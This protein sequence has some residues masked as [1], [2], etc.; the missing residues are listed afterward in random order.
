V[1]IFAIEFFPC[2]GGMA[3]GFQMAGIEFDMAVDIDENAVVSY[4]KNLGHK[5]I[6]MDVRDLL[7]MV[8]LGWRPPR[9]D[10]LCA[11]PPC[12]PWSRAGKRLGTD[13]ERDMLKQTAELIKLLRPR[14]YLIGN[15]P[16]LQD[17]SSWNVVQDVIGGLTAHGYCT[18]DYISLD[19]ADY[20][21]PQNRV[22][23]FWFGHLDGPCIRWP[24]RTHC[25]PKTR[26]HLQEALPGSG[27]IK[28][29]PWVTCRQA[30]RH[31][32]VEE[33]G[34]PVR[35]KWKPVDHEHHKA[36]DAD[37]PA[38]TLTK[39]TRSDGALLAAGGD[40]ATIA[41]NCGHV[42]RGTLS[43]K[44]PG[45]KTVQGGTVTYDP[46]VEA[47]APAK[48]KRKGK[49]GVRN[50]DIHHPP[51]YDD[52]PAKTVRAGNGGGSNRSMVLRQPSLFADMVVR[53]RADGSVRD[54]DIDSPAHT[55][56]AG[57]SSTER[58][59]VG[60]VSDEG[61]VAQRDDGSVRDHEADAPAHTI[62]AAG[63]ANERHPPSDPA[64]LGAKRRGA[65]SGEALQWPWDRPATT[66]TADPR[67]APPGHH[68]ASFLS[69]EESKGKKGKLKKRP[70]S[71]KGPQWQR[72]Y[73]AD[74]PAPAVLTDTD[75]KTG[76]GV[77]LEWPWERPST[78]VMAGIDKIAPAGE[79]AGQFG[80]NAI[81]LSE[82]AAAI[83]Q[84]FPDGWLF[85]GKSKK[86]RWSQLGMA[87]PPALAFAVAK[88]VV[89][90]LE[91]QMEIAER[92][93]A[94]GS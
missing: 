41:C 44:C 55:V 85:A 60:Q 32:P 70:Q 15:V 33:L 49:A 7:R 65:Q 36:S 81:V 46:P 84:G 58:L 20:G 78:S 43:M 82:K 74:G 37:A 12:T 93:C 56:R 9:L 25:D 18:A 1:D 73:P 23:P 62:R 83:L 5:P 17:S 16:G 8:R 61:V 75:R 30:L 90:Q 53:Q 3:K 51:S 71:T 50:A 28:P 31:L 92:K 38:R 34:R 66:V 54:H 29:L 87:M 27:G 52:A 10:F 22:R 79:H 39:N 77:K 67:L 13:D 64:T 14:A 91:A 48:K 19:A 47:A 89:K 59:I 11:D 2:S 21:V 6:R 88:S 45:C 86:A 72:R 68:E 4:E 80:P 26:E 42:F 35:L 94:T 63:R 69:P 76:N 57:R 24:L 40:V